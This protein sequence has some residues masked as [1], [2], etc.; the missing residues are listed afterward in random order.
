MSPPINTGGKVLTTNYATYLFNQVIPT[1]DINATITYNTEWN[2][3]TILQYKFTGLVGAP[4]I[5]KLRFNNIEPHYD[6]GNVDS[7]EI[8]LAY[9]GA[10]GAGHGNEYALDQTYKWGGVQNTKYMNITALDHENN[11]LA[12]DTLYLRIKLDFVI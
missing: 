3:M 9:N 7:R 6:C 2:H 10:A 12:F 11:R 4:E 5:I 8:I 1:E